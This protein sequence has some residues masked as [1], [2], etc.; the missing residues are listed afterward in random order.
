MHVHA[1]GVVL[2][3]RNACTVFALQSGQPFPPWPYMAVSSKQVSMR[4]VR[5][6]AQIAEPKLYTSQLHDVV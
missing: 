1:A 5:Q 4:M 3:T 2:G 6:E